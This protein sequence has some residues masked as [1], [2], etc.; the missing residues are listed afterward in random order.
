MNSFDQIRQWAHARN[1]I[2]GSNP[3]SQFVKLAEEVGELASGIGK[4]N[5]A[6]IEDAIGD[7]AVVITIMASQYGM[8]V[9]D[10]IASAYA[11]IKDRKG[12]MVDG[13]FIKEGDV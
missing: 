4:D 13:I 11:H 2:D 3:K 10:C 7:I 5:L 12:K 1:L 9:E 8:Q 6:E